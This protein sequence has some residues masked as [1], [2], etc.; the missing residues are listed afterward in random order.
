MVWGMISCNRE[1]QLLMIDETLNAKMYI[2]ILDE[3]LL[4]FDEV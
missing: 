4:E 2:K 3:N 1:H